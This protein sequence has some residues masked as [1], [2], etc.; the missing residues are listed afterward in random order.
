[1]YQRLHWFFKLI[2]LL[3]IVLT[4][5][6]LINYV[7]PK[8][9]PVSYKSNVQISGLLVRNQVWEGDIKI[10][11]DV[12]T[13]LGTKITIKPGTKITVSINNDS[14]N[15]DYLP[16]HLR[17]G[18]NTEKPYHG[19]N[20]GEPFWDEAEKIQIHLSSLDAVGTK[21]QPIIF[22]SD[23]A[24]GSPYD[25]NTIEV[26]K[27]VIAFADLSNYRRLEIG[28]DVT[29]RNS[30]F[31]NIGECGVC[32]YTGSP[33]VINN[34]FENILRESI[35]ILKASPRITDNLFINLTGAAIR[36][37]SR[38]FASPIISYNTFETPQQLTIDVLSGGEVSSGVIS[39]NYFAGNTQLNLACDSKIRISQNIILGQIRFQSPGCGGSYVFGPNHWGSSNLNG[40][41]KSSL[42]NIDSN[43]KVVIPTILKQVPERAGRRTND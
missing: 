1:M 38:R 18:V 31:F 5:W 14:S 8:L 23:S 20:T 15:M 22:K 9:L 21:Q 7:L 29:I 2:S 37:D 41:Y 32:I 19:I 25:F 3:A 16:W 42:T 30:R 36:I 27:G 17:S 35:Y 28:S 26:K 4:L 12:M 11:G 43:F 10:T 40:V 33:S 13:L 24:N 6:L 39:F 34:T